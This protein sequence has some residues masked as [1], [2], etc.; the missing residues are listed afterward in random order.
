MNTRGFSLGDLGNS[1]PQP[2]GAVAGKWLTQKS[3]VTCGLSP[4]AGTLVTT[5]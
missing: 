3:S 1:A 4:H 2:A 5:I